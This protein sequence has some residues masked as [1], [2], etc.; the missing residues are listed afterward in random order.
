MSSSLSEKWYDTTLRF[1]SATFVRTSRPRTRVRVNPQIP[2]LAIPHD[3]THAG[4]IGMPPGRA[5]A[6]G[7]G[8]GARP[9]R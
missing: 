6:C 8:P 3:R 1:S 2:A 7:I 9:G 4:L 5:Q